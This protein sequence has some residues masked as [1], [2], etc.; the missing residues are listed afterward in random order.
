MPLIQAKGQQLRVEVPARGLVVNV[1]PERMT[2]VFGNLLNNAAKY[3]DNGGE[4]AISARYENH[5]VEVTIADT[6]RGIE[7]DLM[8]RIFD[9]FTQGAQGL[10]RHQGGWASG[11]R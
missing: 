5:Q 2:Q 4:I 9:L 11:S 3:T 1:D 8:P 7:P 10:E 6:G